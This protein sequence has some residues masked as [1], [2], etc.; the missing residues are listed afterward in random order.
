MERQ[1]SSSVVSRR[2]LR[3]VFAIALL[4]ALP[5]P[6]ARAQN[7]PKLIQPLKINAVRIEVAWPTGSA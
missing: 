2:L 6:R 5:I 4:M 1:A 7:E 3:G